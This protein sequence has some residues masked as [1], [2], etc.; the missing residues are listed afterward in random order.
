MS[1][2]TTFITLPSGVDDAA[3][4]YTSVFKGSKI[5]SKS[6][7]GKDQPLP[8]GT[9]MTV[10]LD[11]DGYHLVLLQGGD[12]FRDK[13]GEGF[14]MQVSCETQAE[15]DAYT[16]QLT[17]NGGEV[18]PCGWIKDRFG[19]SW[20]ITPVQLLRLIRDPD[21]AKANRAM[22]AMMK[23]TKIDIAEIERAAAKT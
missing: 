11:L 1:K 16:E 8:E 17:A 7:Y 12:Y 4:L 10:E 18:G 21:K 23:M 2:I 13:L 14:S 6:H 3:K 9:V 22:Q 19:V 5:T 20:Q 15:V